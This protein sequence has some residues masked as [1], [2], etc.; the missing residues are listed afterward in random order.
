MNFGAIGTIVGHELIHAFD[1]QGSQFDE[2]GNLKNWWHKKT[3]DAFV[4]KTK[5]FI[6]TYNSIKVEEIDEY[7]SRKNKAFPTRH[8]V[9][10]HLVCIVSLYKCGSGGF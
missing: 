2:N 6:E 3:L 10:G 4:E 8:V 5:C 7:V 9:H 1:D